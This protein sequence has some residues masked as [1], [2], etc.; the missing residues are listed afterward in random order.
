MDHFLGDDIATA[1]S[2]SYWHRFDLL[3]SAFQGSGVLILPGHIPYLQGLVLHSCVTSTS[4]MSL[5]RSVFR[6]WPECDQICARGW[7]LKAHKH[8]D[9]AMKSCSPTGPQN[10]ALGL[11]TV[12]T[13][14]CLHNLNNGPASDD[15]TFGVQKTDVFSIHKTPFSMNKC[16]TLFS[17][18]WSA[19]EPVCLR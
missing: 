17:M 2:S 9:I 4:D 15:A 14:C 12:A 5:Q 11:Y 3:S 6:R 18:Q 16:W 8:R 7:S 13:A 1:I 19:C 10:Q